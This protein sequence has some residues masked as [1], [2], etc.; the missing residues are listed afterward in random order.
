MGGLNPLSRPSA[1]Q[2]YLAISFTW[3]SFLNLQIEYIYSE[4]QESLIFNTL[5]VILK[6]EVWSH[7]L[8]NIE[9]NSVCFLKAVV[10]GNSLE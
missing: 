1:S 9:L 6:E 8:V 3:D 7:I 4:A 5:E 10:S 2:A